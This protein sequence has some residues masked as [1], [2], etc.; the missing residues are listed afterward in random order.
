MGRIFF[1]L[2]L[3]LII[4]LS[5]NSVF[6]ITI[7]FNPVSSTVDLGAPAGA[8]LII[9]GLGDAGAPSLGTFD[10]DISFNP[11]ILSLSE[12]TFGD[13]L[14]GDQL[15]LFGSGSLT[16]TTLG[17]GTVNL[18]ELSF[19]FADDL[20]TLQADSFTLATLTFNTLGHGTSTLTLSSN[21]LGDAFGDP[22]FATLNNGDITVAPVPEPGTMILLGSGIAGFILGRK[23]LKGLYR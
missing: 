23:K 21:A 6:A 16:A 22:L 18:F 17:S 12:V 3:S 11:T 13:P 4:L 14:L 2:L 10:L 8:A 9:S 15:D 5:P 1:G 19:D 7:S 20:N